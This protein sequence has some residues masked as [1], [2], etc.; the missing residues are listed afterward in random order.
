MYGIYNVNSKE[1]YV[2]SVQT[3]LDSILSLSICMTLSEFLNFSLFLHL[4]SKH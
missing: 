4:Y 2:L 1:F 3:A